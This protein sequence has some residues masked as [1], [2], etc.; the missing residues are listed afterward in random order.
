GHNDVGNGPININD[1]SEGDDYQP[2]DRRHRLTL[3]GFVDLP[4]YNGD[5]KFARGMLN[6]WQLGLITPIVSSPPLSNLVTNVDL[7][8]DGI[9][10][11]ILPGGTFNG[12][13]PRYGPDGLRQLVN[14]FN[15]MLAGK[16]TSRG[17]PIPEIILP[18]NIDNGDTFIS[19]DVRLTRNISIGE[20]VK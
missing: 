13:G 15:S 19:Q 12:F 17:Q 7:D 5:S 2:S 18:D 6:G 9:N 10:F 3:S 8:G 20:K 16:T 4:G 1:F 11:L 14:N